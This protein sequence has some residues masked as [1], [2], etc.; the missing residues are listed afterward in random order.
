MNLP[1]EK[2][3][4]FHANAVALA[5]HVRRPE[6]F[7]IPAVAS[8]CLPVTGGIGRAAEKGAKFGDLLSYENAAT[9]VSGDFIDAKLAIDFTQG[10]Y[11]ENG[12]ATETSAQS[13]LTGLRITS[14]NRVLEIEVLEAKMAATSDRQGATNFHSLSAEFQNVRVDD[15]G[16]T[17]VSHCDVFQIFGTKQS[18][19]EAFAASQDFRDRYGACFFSAEGPDPGRQQIPESDGLIYGTIVSTLEWEGKA[20]EGA[21][22]SGN[23]VTIEDF[24]SIYFGEIVIEEGFRRLTL[25]RFQL[26]SPTGGEGSGVEVQTNGSSWPPRTS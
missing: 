26:G 20:P 7:Y 2:R 15:V 23:R 3:F 16:L 17:I 4:F 25:L 6:D 21:V 10:N 1:V 11:G 9:H 18:L 14:G 13:S 5:G 24:G 22:I 12:L 8:S 19:T